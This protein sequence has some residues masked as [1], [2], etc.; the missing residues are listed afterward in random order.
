MQKEAQVRLEGNKVSLVYLLLKEFLSYA[1]SLLLLLRGKSQ[2]LL[3][4]WE[5]S[6]V[7]SSRS[8]V[9]KVDSIT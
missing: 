2:K 1:E 3:S 8:A 4:C 7:D 5:D 6:S 9:G